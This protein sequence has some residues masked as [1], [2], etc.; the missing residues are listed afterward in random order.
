MEQETSVALGRATG[1]EQ[2]VGDFGECRVPRSSNPVLICA[3]ADHDDSASARA[4]D[5]LKV[6]VREHLWEGGAR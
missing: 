4:C 5:G 2:R 1:L 3:W 6:A